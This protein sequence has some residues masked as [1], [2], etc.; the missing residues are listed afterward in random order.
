M[1]RNECVE[2]ISTFSSI[3]NVPTL[4]PCNNSWLILL[5]FLRPLACWDC[6][7]ESWRRHGCLSLVNVVCCQVECSLH[8]ADHSC[9]RVLLCVVYPTECDHEASA[10][11]RPMPTRGCCIMR[12]GGGAGGSLPV[13]AIIFA[14]QIKCFLLTSYKM[15]LILGQALWKHTT[16]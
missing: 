5:M 9:K 6:G 12:G 13:L 4:V 3:I 2:Q 14:V 7:F 1:W 15:Y 16:W 8:R 10:M 11:S